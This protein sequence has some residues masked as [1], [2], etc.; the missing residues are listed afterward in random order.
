MLELVKEYIQRIDDCKDYNAYLEVFREEAVKKA[1]QLDQKIKN[2][3]DKLGKLFGAIV[4]IKDNIVYSNH[5]SSASSRMLEDYVSPFS[6]TAVERLLAED[7]IIIGRCNCDEFS[8]GA[9]NQ[10]SAWGP[11]KNAHDPSRIPGGSSGG[12]AVSC[13]LDLCHIALGSDTGGSVRQPAAYNAVYGFKPS[14][15]RISRW[16]LISYASSLDQI[17]ILSSD[18]DALESCYQVIAGPDS[19][20]STAIP[21]K[22][23]IDEGDEL[24]SW[25]FVEDFFSEDF[26]AKNA[27]QRSM[28]FIRKIEESFGKAAC[29]NFEFKDWLIPCYYIICTAEA[30]SNLARYDGIRYGFS[31]DGHFNDFK[32][33]IRTSRTQAFGKEVKKRI[34][35]GNYVLSEGYADA[36]FNKALGIRKYLQQCMDKIFEDFDFLVLPVTS[37]VA[38]RLDKKP[39]AL[40]E[41]RGDQFTVLANL[42][43]LPSIS[44][45]LENKSEELP[46]G[47]Q[48]LSKYKSDLKLLNLAR[49]LQEQGIK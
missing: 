10:S 6:A 15:G 14:Y 2:K 38:R 17:G 34:I 20:D 27:C 36:Y 22:E 25:A 29:L 3:P 16:G 47:I 35:L 12:S 31:A 30:S 23:E 24:K 32:E 13:A 45:P 46:L 21:E 26:M 1:G 40:E 37:D 48:I 41:Y 44:I 11:A 7:A 18:L 33:K 9:S 19:Y 43:G 39:D 28:R 42:C 49:R 8:M 4:S 5:K